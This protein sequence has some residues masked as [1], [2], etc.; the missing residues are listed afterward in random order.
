MSAFP[1]TWGGA[2]ILRRGGGNLR[3]QGAFVEKIQYT[4]IQGV[5]ICLFLITW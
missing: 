4:D 2:F 3:Q 5:G 1:M